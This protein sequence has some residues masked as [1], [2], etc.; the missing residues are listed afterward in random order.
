MLLYLI[1][2]NILIIKNIDNIQQGTDIIGKS[3]NKAPRNIKNI[4]FLLASLYT[5]IP[6][7]NTGL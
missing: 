5:A 1:N 2:C 3:I 7:K 6:S 4:K